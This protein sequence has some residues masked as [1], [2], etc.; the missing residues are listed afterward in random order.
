MSL[1]LVNEEEAQVNEKAIAP[2]IIF[3]DGG[4]KTCTIVK[5]WLKQEGRKEGKQYVIVDI[6][7]VHGTKCPAS[8]KIDQ[9][10]S[11]KNGV[12]YERRF[13]STEVMPWLRAVLNV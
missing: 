8:I 12:L 2:Y 1:A 10:D 4:C 7:K 13:A 11:Q 3:F 9:T 6:T 5:G